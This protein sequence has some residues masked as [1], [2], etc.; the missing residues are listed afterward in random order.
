MTVH[1]W[2]MSSTFERSNSLA[3]H[4]SNMTLK[5]FK[6]SLSNVGDAQDDGSASHCSAT[7][8]ALHGR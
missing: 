2:R 8:Y 7:Y 3:H 1:S 4:L 6:R 5:G